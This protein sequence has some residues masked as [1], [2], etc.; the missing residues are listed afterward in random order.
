[1][2]CRRW[3]NPVNFFC[4]KIISSSS[5]NW[6]QV[7]LIIL[8]NKWHLY[9]RIL[10]ANFIKD[11]VLLAS[12]KSSKIWWGS[13]ISINNLQVISYFCYYYCLKLMSI[14]CSYKNCAAVVADLLIYLYDV[15]SNYKSNSSRGHVGSLG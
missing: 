8:T 6:T 3:R 13:D 1:M 7:T 9:V 14:A 10:I 5:Y 11:C 15:R 2:Y 4:S 12:K